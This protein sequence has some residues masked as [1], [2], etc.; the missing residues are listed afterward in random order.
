[1]PG[2]RPCLRSLAAEREPL[3]A[4]GVAFSV[5]VCAMIPSWT[6]YPRGDDSP[7]YPRRPGEN[8]SGPTIGPPLAVQSGIM[9]AGRA[10]DKG[11]AEKLARSPRPPPVLDLLD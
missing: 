9:V 2:T 6:G 4:R 7:R 5:T 11:A 10:T 8:E 3:P 1:M